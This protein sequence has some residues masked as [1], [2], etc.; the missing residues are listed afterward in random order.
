MLYYF[1]KSYQEVPEAI[2]NLE[3]EGRRSKENLFG[4]YAFLM[5][6]VHIVFP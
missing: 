4:Q 1:L 2:R 5:N 3:V 6:A